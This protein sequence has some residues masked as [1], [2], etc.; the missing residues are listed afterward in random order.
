MKIHKDT[1]IVAFLKQIETCR[2][3]VEFCT[4]QGD[5]LDLKSALARYLLAALSANDGITYSG[6]VI[7]EYDDDYALLLPYLTE[8]NG[9]EQNEAV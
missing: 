4:D 7:C 8:S 2:G 9:G 3:Q 5:R 1:D 6:E